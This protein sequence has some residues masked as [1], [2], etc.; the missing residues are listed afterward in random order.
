[1]ASVIEIKQLEDSLNAKREEIKHQVQHLLCDIQEEIPT[2]SNNTLIKV[3]FQRYNFNA[4]GSRK[5][6]EK[7]QEL[8]LVDKK[9]IRKILKTIHPSKKSTI[10]KHKKKGDQNCRKDKYKK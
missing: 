10:C 6:D 1:M 2:I 3:A 9:K 8:Y 4:D 5:V 7:G